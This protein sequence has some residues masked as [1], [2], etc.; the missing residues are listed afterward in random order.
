MI[1]FVMALIAFIAIL[2]VIA[3]LIQNPKGG[4]ID[5]T[6]GAGANQMFGAARSAE[7]IEKATWV[8]A[9]VLMALCVLS[10]FMLSK[11]AAGPALQIQG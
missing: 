1:N 3:V 4:G 11:G 7:T 8:L 9:A 10:Y 2:L 6:Y 5:S